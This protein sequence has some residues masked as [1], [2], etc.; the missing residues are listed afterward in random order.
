MQKKGVLVQVTTKEEVKNTI[1]KEISLRFELSHLLLTL[2][3][4]LCKNLGLSGEGILAKDILGSQEELQQHREA[5][6]AF[7]LFMDP[8]INQLGQKLLLSSR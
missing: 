6:E 1:M 4:D 5:K 2:E 8:N 7:Q 3:D